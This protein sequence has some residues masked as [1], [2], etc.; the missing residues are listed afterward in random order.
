MLD[1]LELR[2]SKRKL[3]L[4]DRITE[5]DVR[6]FTTLVR[7][8]TAYF[9][10]FKCNRN[11]LVDL[12]ELRDYTRAIYHT[13]ASPRPSGSVRS[14]RIITAAIARSILRVFF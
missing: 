5:A 3:L 14:R 1:T 8:D 6:L 7:F 9:G 12:T 13:Q 11:R 2:L 10:H 4:G